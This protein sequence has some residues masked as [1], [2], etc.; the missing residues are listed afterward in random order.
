MA[1]IILIILLVI[2]ILF[3]LW[4]FVLTTG[5][6]RTIKK[7]DS[8]LSGIDATLIKYQEL[9]LNLLE[10]SPYATYEGTFALESMKLRSYMPM[11]ERL[12]AISEMKQAYQFLTSTK[13][14][15]PELKSNEDF[16]LLHIAVI[17]KEEYLQTSLRLY[18]TNTDSL[19]QKI[20]SFPIHLVAARLHIKTRAIIN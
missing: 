13:E 18:N 6:I 2:V 11:A 19:N 20:T 15:S 14:I 8:T 3:T 10:F 17:E 4:L 12:K 9:L 16:K 5:L 1:K 7:V